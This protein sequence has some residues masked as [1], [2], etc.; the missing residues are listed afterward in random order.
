MIVLAILQRSEAGVLTQATFGLHSDVYKSIKQDVC[1]ECL[2]A[3]E[4]QC[5]SIEP[6]EA[7]APHASFK[8]DKGFSLPS[9]Q[10]HQQPLTAMSFP[11][12]SSNVSALHQ[13][14]PVE[15]EIFCCLMP[16]GADSKAVC[17]VSMFQSHS[18]Q[19]RLPHRCQDFARNQPAISRNF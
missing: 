12:T 3:Q 15:P 11:G 17:V 7:A 14:L 10:E 19:Q 8:G 6:F 1:N 4:L 16:Q 13:S 2:Y 9:R 18:H 5:E